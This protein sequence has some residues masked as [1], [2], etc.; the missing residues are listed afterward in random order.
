MND[1]KRMSVTLPSG[2]TID[3]LFP[4][5]ATDADIWF[6]REMVKIQINTWE[7]WNLER[8]KKLADKWC[9]EITDLHYSEGYP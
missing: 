2:G 7:R 8:Q 9:K 5:V 4:E 1:R 6:A 3:F